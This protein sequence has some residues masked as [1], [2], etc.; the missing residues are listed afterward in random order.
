MHVYDMERE[1]AIRIILTR[2]PNA[3]ET[4]FQ[5]NGNAS[6]ESAAMRKAGM[7][8]PGALPTPVR[9]LS[10]KLGCKCRK[11]ACMKKYC[12]CYAGNVKCSDQCR[13]TG[14]KNQ[15]VPGV[16]DKPPPPPTVVRQ[17]ASYQEAAY[18]LAFLKHGT[19]EK[20]GRTNSRDHSEA[21][22]MPSLASE[23]S[24]TGARVAQK[25]AAGIGSMP[26]PSTSEKAAVNALQSS[27]KTAV[28]ALLMAARAMVGGSS[29]AQGTSRRGLQNSNGLESLSAAATPPV[30][31]VAVDCATPDTSF[32]A[33]EH[34]ET[35]QRSLFT[36]PKRKAGEATPTNGAKASAADVSPKRDHPGD[37]ITPSV[38]Q[39]MKRSRIGSVIK[40]PAENG[41][42]GE[43]AANASSA[44][45]EMSTPAKGTTA[46][47][48]LTPVSARIIDFKKMSVTKI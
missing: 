15:P 8:A 20:P 31:N 9:Q 43:A 26:P 1:T 39:K 10:H 44:P 48:D 21:G 3:F 28:N 6:A 24:P 37:T 18:S 46:K 23:E 12:E 19:P 14:C 2:N 42:N 25:L 38:D 41:D 16:D 4:K 40:G 11:S 29:G 45:M 27:E 5:K 17:D 33:E 32:V 35:P 13:C 7:P 22:S 34:F 47:P 30:N 36:S